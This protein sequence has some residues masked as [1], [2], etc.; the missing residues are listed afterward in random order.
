MRLLIKQRVFSWTDTYDVYDEDSQPK[1]VV[2]AEFFSFGHQIHIYDRNQ[3]E[4]GVIRQRLF[5][6]LP[7]F[8][9]EIHGRVIGSVQKQFTFFRPQYEVDCNGWRVEGDF[10]G[11]NYI[12]YSGC[13]AVVRI[14]KQPLSW[15]DTYVLD[16]ANP[17]DE[18]MGLLLVI[19]ID[20]ANCTEK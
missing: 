7:Q 16:F 15:G 6:L 12:V 8:D 9:L 5:A 4:V 10:L 1:Y 19:A 20:A 11:W 18:I 17:A 2:K 3:R 13:S 14:S